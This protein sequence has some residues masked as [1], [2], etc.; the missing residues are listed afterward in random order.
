MEA[1]GGNRPDAAGKA[2]DGDRRQARGPRPVVGVAPALDSAGACERARLAL[3]AGGDRPDAAGK[4]DDGDRGMAV[5][6]RPVAEPAAAA[7]ALD[8]TRLGERAGVIASG[9]DCDDAACEAG[10]GDRR[11]PVGRR[12]VAELAEV[13]PTPA[14][15]SAGGREGA[16]V[17]VRGRDCPDA[18]A[19]A[20][21]CGRRSSS[22]PRV[23]RSRCRPST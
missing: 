9:G 23:R 8:P 17:V 5:D 12:A 21:D 11:V 6:R 3:A 2:G 16:A 4:A 22:R 1:A 20:K 7:P 18:A 15:D 13:V 14:L 10:N 19:K